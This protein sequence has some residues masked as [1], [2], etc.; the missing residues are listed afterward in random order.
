MFFSFKLVNPVR[1]RQLVQY[2]HAHRTA[3]MEGETGQSKAE[4]RNKK[5]APQSI[6]QRS[7]NMRHCTSPTL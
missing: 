4:L 5:D 6:K 3:E 2:Q 7:Q 1:L